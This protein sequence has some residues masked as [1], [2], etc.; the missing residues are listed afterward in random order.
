MMKTLGHGVAAA[1]LALCVAGT[2]NAQMSKPSNISVRAGIFSPTDSDARDIGNTWFAAGLEWKGGDL[3]RSGS[4]MNAHA[5]WSISVDWYGKDDAS[6]VPVLFNYVEKT[7]NFYWSAGIGFAFNSIPGSGYVPTED[8][9]GDKKTSTKFGYS[10]AL[11]WDAPSNNGTPWFVE[12]R[13]F[14]NA[15]SEL[16]GFGLYVGIRF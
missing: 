5:H 3:E 6:A 9:P 4:M 10:L 13:Y 1:T 2:A 16:N 14:G 11:G 15:Q 12:G 7:T 8:A